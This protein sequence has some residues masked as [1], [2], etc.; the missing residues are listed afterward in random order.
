M[1]GVVTDG[2]GYVQAVY[3]I[4]IL[5]FVAYAASLWMRRNE[6]GS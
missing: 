6:L 3:G 5:V 2:W 1:M 4:T